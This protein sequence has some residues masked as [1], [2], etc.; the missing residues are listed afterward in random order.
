[1]TNVA[2]IYCE[3]DLPSMTVFELAVASAIGRQELSSN[4]DLMEILGD[5]FQRS[6][7]D[8]DVVSAL[9]KMEQQGWVR[10]AGE[11]LV[12]Y[13]LTP[14]GIDYV[15][16]LYGGCIRMIDRGLGILKVSFLLQALEFP[17]EEDNA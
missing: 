9:S 11:T 8:R 7:D 13:R 3:H 16:T 17:K 6:V 14:M 10:Q 4:Q 5:W 12:A 1:M 2:T 15:T